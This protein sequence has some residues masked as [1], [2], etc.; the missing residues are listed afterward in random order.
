VIKAG[1]EDTIQYARTDRALSTGPEQ[2]RSGGQKSWW[3]HRGMAHPPHW[4]FLVHA[5][6]ERIHRPPGQPGGRGAIPVHIPPILQR[7]GL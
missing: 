4:H 5:G 2:R 6:A 3:N 7:L 1:S